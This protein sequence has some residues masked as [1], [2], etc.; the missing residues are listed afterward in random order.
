ML[1]LKSKIREIP[2]W[3]KPGV[4][5]KDIAPL[6][7][8]AAAF[9]QTIDELTAPY[10][11]KPV[12]VVVAIDAR[13]FLLA[14]AVAYKLKAG[15]ALVRKKGKLPW[16]TINRKYALEYGSN[17]I[18]MHEDAVLPGQKVLMVDDVLA[19][20][21]TMEAAI[22]LVRQLGGEIIGASFLIG[23]SFLKGKEKLNGVEIKELVVY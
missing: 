6:L 15:V 21:G 11:G 4:N 12:D 17:T 8:D 22:E 16:K 19:T 20:G 9:Q 13:G 7:Q 1:D 18:E 23:L 10:I 3:P 2:D 14:T 5:F